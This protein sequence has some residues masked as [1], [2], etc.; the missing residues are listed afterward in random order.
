MKSQTSTLIFSMIRVRL[1]VCAVSRSHKR[2][3][4]GKREY[5]IGYLRL[6]IVLHNETSPDAEA[7]GAVS[8]VVLRSRPDAVIVVGTSLKI[9]GVRSIVREMC[10]TVSG[11]RDGIAIWINKDAEPVTGELKKLLGLGG[12][13]PL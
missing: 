7:I 8:V 9:I 12:A 6:R 4:Q 10:R 2:Q 3:Q 13:R 11:H 1:H 5:G